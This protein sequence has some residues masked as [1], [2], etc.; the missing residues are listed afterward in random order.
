[1]SLGWKGLLPL[2]IANIVLT[3]VV[4]YF[5]P[6]LTDDNP[7]AGGVPIAAPAD[8]EEAPPAEGDADD[9]APADEDADADEEETP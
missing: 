2:S 9:E 6:Q 5:L 8:V 3:A 7:Q 4:V 1:M